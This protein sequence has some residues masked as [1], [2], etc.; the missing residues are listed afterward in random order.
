MLGKMRSDKWRDW[1]EVRVSALAQSLSAKNMTKAGVR[2][3]ASDARLGQVAGK[4]R[5]SL[6]D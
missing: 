1:Q 6:A 3:Y 2:S 5:R 4:W